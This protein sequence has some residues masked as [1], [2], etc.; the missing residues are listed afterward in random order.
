MS[1]DPFLEDGCE[2]LSQMNC[3]YKDVMFYKV[4]R[5]DIEVFQGNKEAWPLY[6]CQGIL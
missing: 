5:G 3:E 4:I 2:R 1:D 6:C